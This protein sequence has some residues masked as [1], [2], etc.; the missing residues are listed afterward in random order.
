MPSLRRDATQADRNRACWLALSADMQAALA[1]LDPHRAI[2]QDELEQRFRVR[3]ATLRALAVRRM[4]LLTYL[5]LD[6]GDRA[7]RWRLTMFGA[8]ILAAR[9]MPPRRLRRTAS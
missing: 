6:G 7:R 4:A 2:D 9:P 5:Q 1:R 3:R 8:D